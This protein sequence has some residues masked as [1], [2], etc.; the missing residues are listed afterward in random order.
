MHQSV[1]IATPT[2]TPA[3][4]GWR[5]TAA[6]LALTAIPF[7]AGLARLA[8][9]AS[10]AP[11]TPE[12]ARF[13][14]APVP[15]VIHIIGASLFCVLGALQLVPGTYRARPA[16]HRLAGRVLVVAGMAAALSG[17]WMTQSYA[18]PPELQGGL[19]YGFR[20]LI[21]T[22]M[23]A[24]LALGW[25]AALRRKLG[26]HRAWMIRA[27]AIGQGAGTQALIMLP[28][29][30]IIGE[31]RGLPRDLL[32]IAAWLINLAVA[33]WAIRRRALAAGDRE[34]RRTG[35]KETRSTKLA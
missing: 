14:A 15:V 13:V 29:A 33:E 19:L 6:L 24:A 10:G 11:A 23:A 5:T 27:Y 3:R 9:L 34:T 25:R 12:S 31:V 26:A 7:I 17:L 30:L 18:L 4:S 22:A 35:D 16:W 8:G 1:R 28:P 32:M 20:M 21:G 2:A